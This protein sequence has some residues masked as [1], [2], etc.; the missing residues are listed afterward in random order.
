MIIPPIRWSDIQLREAGLRVP[1]LLESQQYLLYMLLS[2]VQMNP[3]QFISDWNED[4]AIEINDFLN[5]CMNAILDE[6]TVT[7]PLFMQVDLM[8]A[9]GAPLAGAGTLTYTAG[10]SLPYGYYMLTANT[11]LFGIEN[12]VWLQAGEYNY[13]GWASLSPTGGNTEVVLTDG[14]SVIDTIISAISQNGAANSRVKHTGTFTVPND[15][16]YKIVAA[17]NGTGTSTN[18]QCNWTSHHIRQTS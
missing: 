15:G 14:A 5:E 3:A 2:L 9:N 16:F 17:N 7:Y 18:R 10:S 6:D 12:D 8:C 11:T 1:P 4:D 13:T